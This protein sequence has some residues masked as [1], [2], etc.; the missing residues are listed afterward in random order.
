MP[1]AN[2]SSIP[3]APA[4][5]ETV[6]GA[7]TD[8]LPTP[9]AIAQA[10]PLEEGDEVAA[11]EPLLETATQCRNCGTPTSG[12]FC[13]ECG[14]TTNEHVPGAREFAYDLFHNYLSPKGMLWQTL[15]LLMIHPGRLTVEY[16]AGRRVRFIAPPRLYLGASVA[17][18][19]LVKLFGVLLPEVH[20]KGR[21]YAVMFSYSQPNAAAAP[22]ALPASPQKITPPA[23]KPTARPDQP[24]WLAKFNPEW[25]RKL[26][27]F[28]K[29]S[30]A[31]KAA[32]LSNGFFANVPYAMF[33][34]LPLFALYLQL[35]Y[36]RARLRFGNHMVFTLHANAFSFIVFCLITMLP[37]HFS[38]LVLKLLI[39]PRLWPTA[40]DQVGSGLLAQMQHLLAWFAPWDSVKIV[41]SLWLLCWLPLALRRV[42]GGSRL[43]TAWR[44][45]V[46]LGLHLTVMVVA[47]FMAEFVA[48]LA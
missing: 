34:T 40:A 32:I 13:P 16:I 46:L 38:E 37:G 30:D 11:A 8:A 3:A 41:L 33:C 44:L 18:F 10:Q 42:Y 43:A 29:Q 4:P 6:P 1:D 14:Q 21:Q 7:A 22:Q 17:L 47:T 36:P 5:A 9:P 31:Q 26:L 19:A 23:A 12:R 45:P 25:D 35:L 15:Y 39:L 2:P 20:V 28:G 48:I 24:G 27:Q